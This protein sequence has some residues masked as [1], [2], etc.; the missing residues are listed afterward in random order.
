MEEEERI[1]MERGEGTQRRR[2]YSGVRMLTGYY[3]GF[4]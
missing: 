2:L 4:L 3:L 1:R